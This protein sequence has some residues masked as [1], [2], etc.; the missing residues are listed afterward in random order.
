MN[1][2]TPPSFCAWA[3]VCSARVVLPDDSGP[4]DL[5]HAAA[6]QAADAER[7][8]ELIEPV[9]IAGMG[10]MASLPPS[11][12]IEPLPNCF[13]IWPTANFDGLAAFLVRAVVVLVTFRAF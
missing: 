12:M 3:I 1:A 2:A 4:E 9:E 8:V 5:D 7:P 13:S 6:G 10:A 11:R